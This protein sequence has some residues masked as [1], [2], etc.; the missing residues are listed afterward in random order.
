MK[1][2][3]KQAKKLNQKFEPKKQREE[4]LS[5]LI[6]SY[7]VYIETHSIRLLTH[8]VNLP[9]RISELKNHHFIDVDCKIVGKHTNKFGRK[10]N[11]Y[12]YKL[13]VDCFDKVI[14]YMQN[15]LKV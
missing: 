2:T 10:I 4:V 14:E 6:D 12:A 9:E 7:P 3:I 8:I 1:E 11:K 5:I 13:N 15:A